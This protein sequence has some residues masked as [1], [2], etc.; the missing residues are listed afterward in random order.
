MTCTCVLLPFRALCSISAASMF[1][2][3]PCVP[4]EY[5]NARFQFSSHF[6]VQSTTTG[7][8]ER[9]VNFF[10]LICFT[11]LYCCMVLCSPDWCWTH[12]PPN[13]TTCVLRSYTWPHH[14]WL[15]FIHSVS[16]LWCYQLWVYVILDHWNHCSVT[17]QSALYVTIIVRCT[18]FEW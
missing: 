18:V 10:I 6:S 3:P 1:R 7:G 15:L 5:L 8:L 2:T 12:V 4:R 13:S 11:S 16:R 14:T 9:I 17:Y